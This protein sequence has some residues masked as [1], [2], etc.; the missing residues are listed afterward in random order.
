MES[1]PAARSIETRSV[2]AARSTGTRPAS[3]GGDLE[4]S[5]LEDA[6][7]AFPSPAWELSGIPRDG[8]PQTLLE[9]ASAFVRRHH[10]TRSS[11]YTV[12]SLPFSEGDREGE[13]ML[14]WWFDAPGMLLFKQV[15]LLPAGGE[16]KGV[17][18]TTARALLADPALRALGLHTVRVES[19]LKRKFLLHLETVGWALEGRAYGGGDANLSGNADMHAP[20]GEGVA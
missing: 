4:D 5:D 6:L 14:S 9:V 17:L 12:E 10:K 11:M 18:T 15:M 20:A 7:C 16:P 2:T 3:R 19:V 8:P 13:V 1:A